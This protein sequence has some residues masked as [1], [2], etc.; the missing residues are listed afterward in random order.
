V[1]H[2]GRDG[3]VATRTLC[4]DTGMLRLTNRFVAAHLPVPNRLID[5]S[6]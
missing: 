1:D 3:L 4:L 2:V 6:G 5:N